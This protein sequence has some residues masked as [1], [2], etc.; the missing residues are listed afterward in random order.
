MKRLFQSPVTLLVSF[1]GLTLLT[2]ILFF[3]EERALVGISRFLPGSEPFLST[4][5][6]QL[7][8]LGLNTV[9]TL[10][11]GLLA[12]VAFAAYFFSLSTQLHKK[13]TIIFA[14]LFQ[15]IVFFSYPVLS[16]DIFSYIFSDRV[17]TEYG[18]NIW[19]VI[20][21]TFS[22]DP[23]W[24]LSDWKDQ[25]KVYGA[26]N[27][28]IYL[29]AAIIGGENLLLTVALYKL[30][31]VLFAIATL[32]IFVKLI[33]NRSEKDQSQAIKLLFWNPLFV[34]EIAGSGHNDIAMIFFFMVCLLLYWKKQWLWAGVT[35]ALSV[36]IKLITAVFLIFVV[37]DFLRKKEWKAV[38]E[39]GAGFGVINLLAF[40][41]MQVSPLD[42]LSRVMYNNTVYWQSLPSLVHKFWENEKSLFTPLM[43]MTGLTLII[44]QWKK[45]LEPVLVTVLFLLAYLLFF[46]AAYWNWY[47]LWVL[48]LVPFIKM[49]WLRVMILAFSFTS[50]FAYPLLWVSLRF[51]YS[52]IL[53]S[54]VYYAWIFAVPMVVGYVSK[55]KNWLNKAY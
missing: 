51:G 3:R 34:L 38:L 27:Q 48:V 15:L 17:F 39:F 42:F 45:K 49:K 29:P 37:V 53:W 33:E 30:T 26:V 52:N 4:T 14:V 11:F 5:R 46:S 8:T 7:L 25:T 2:W 28:V 19:K 23:Y 12:M 47:V 36:Q 6:E 31:A 41:Y 22:E 44:Y 55:Y 40:W 35:L 32:F 21:N 13:N 54:F 18:Q 9:P 16:T 10:L 43:G 24:L 1:V 20:P 50:L